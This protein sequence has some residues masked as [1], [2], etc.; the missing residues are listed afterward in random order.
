MWGGSPHPQPGFKPGINH[1]KDQLY[2]HSLKKTRIR[3]EIWPVNLYRGGNHSLEKARIRPDVWPV[4]YRGGNHTLEKTRIR[5][6][7]WPVYRVG[8]QKREVSHQ[9][10]GNSALS[11]AARKGIAEH[12]EVGQP[13]N[14]VF[15]QVIRRGSGGSS[16]Y[17]LLNQPGAGYEGGWCT[18][19][20]H[21]GG[22]GRRRN[23]GCLQHHAQ[24][25]RTDWN[26]RFWVGK[27]PKNLTSNPK[28]D[29]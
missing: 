16:P 3:P 5:P 11:L 13:N 15:E 4:N 18:G 1:C 10:Q 2:N 17:P 9:P 27:N 28:M 23:A 14:T 20:N 6:E 25:K 19:I 22:H 7:I 8:R 24:R 29:K 21:D 26:T 12:Y